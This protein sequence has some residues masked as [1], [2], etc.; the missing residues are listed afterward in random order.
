[1][2]RT[3]R[4]GP[5]S[6]RNAS[7]SPARARESRP[8]VT[9]LRAFPSAPRRPSARYIHRPRRELGGPRAPSFP[10]PRCM[11]Y[12]PPRRS[13][14]RIVPQQLETTLEVDDG[15][16]RTGRARSV[17]HSRSPPPRALM[18]VRAA[19]MR[20]RA[21]NRR[22]PVSRTLARVSAG[23][24]TG[25]PGPVI[26]LQAGTAVNYFG[27]GLI[28]PFE[29]IYL[30]QARGFPT[31]TAGLVLATVMGTAAVVTPS[32]GALLDRFRAKP[33]L[34]TGNLAS[35][36]GYAGFAFVDRPW[37]AFV[38]SAV[39]GAG[40]GVANTANQVLSLTL[41]SAEQR[42][43]SIALRRVA[44]N[45]GLGSGA[46]VAG[47]IVASANNLRAFQALYLFD[48]L[49]FA[50]FA[51]VVLVGIPSP[52]LAKAA[53]ASDRGTGFRA[54]AHDRLFLILIAANIVLVMTGGALFSNI[55]APFAKA[56]TPVGPGEIGV[57]IFINTFFIVVAQIP[58]TRVVKRMR[59]TH[60]LAATSALFAIGLLAVLL[61]TLTSS[62]LTAAIVLAGVAIVIA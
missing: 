61:A 15:I 12:R 51:L 57:V 18:N 27:T 5:V 47:F 58:A 11:H 14:H 62:A 32:S 34:I 25:L 56:H 49:T 45:F 42:A 3:H 16:V 48:G 53:S 10:V 21:A 33:I 59:R 28:L 44:G 52:R 54:V 13:A 37:Q 9:I 23:W 17:H 46:T 43:S 24:R 39:G 40:F 29:I 30:H 50:V 36:L 1:M 60:A 8:A 4:C 31:A 19:R 55:L 20:G 26:V 35:A 6:S 7:P 41:V 38:C 2:S 22:K